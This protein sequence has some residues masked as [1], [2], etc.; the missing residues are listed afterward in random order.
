MLD[1]RGSLAVKFKIS[2]IINYLKNKIEWN[3]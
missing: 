2:D 1:K 3:S